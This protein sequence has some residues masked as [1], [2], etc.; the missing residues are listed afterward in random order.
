MSILF[1]QE[2]TNF[3]KKSYYGKSLFWRR[4]IIPYRAISV[5]NI[6]AHMLGFVWM[7]GYTL[8]VYT[9]APV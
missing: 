9:I 2:I 4:Q 3:Y 6:K 7:A 1:K 8:C 5:I